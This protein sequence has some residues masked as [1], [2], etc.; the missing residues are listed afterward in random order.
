LKFSRVYSL[1]KAKLAFASWISQL[2]TGSVQIY[3]WHIMSDYLFAPLSQRDNIRLLQLLPSKNSSKLRCKIF[4][5]TLQNS[6][7]GIRP[8]EALSYV[9]GSEEKP[10]RITVVG[11]QHGER[12]FAITENLHAA[13]SQIQDHDIPRI[14]WI[15]AVSIDQSNNIE[16]SY[17]IPLMAE[18]YAKASRVIV[19]LGEA[20]DDSTQALEAIRT[21]AASVMSRSAAPKLPEQAISALLDRPWF[22]RIWV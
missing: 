12:D 19:W 11:N 1:R 17:Q 3:F 8:Y 22:R 6:D 18:I 15:D 21:A 13:L 20:Q 2:P 10:R 4:E 7:K 5:C 16:K 14:I 9:W